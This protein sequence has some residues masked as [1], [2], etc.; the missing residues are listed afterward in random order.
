M[1]RWNVMGELVGALINAKA[2]P[3]DI[4]SVSRGFKVLVA[5]PNVQSALNIL[6]D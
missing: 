4:K 6:D 1:E 3:A 5:F 2:I